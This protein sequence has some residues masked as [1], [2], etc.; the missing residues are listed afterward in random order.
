MTT[1]KILPYRLSSLVLGSLLG[2]L[3]TAN[4]PA[5]DI[6]AFAGSVPGQ[7]VI[8]NVLIILDNSANWSSTA[9]NA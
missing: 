5:A 9:D 1:A 4:L 2:A 7:A 3:G 6:D 8:P